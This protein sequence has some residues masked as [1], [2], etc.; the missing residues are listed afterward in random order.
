M[1]RHI[2]HVFRAMAHPL[3]R[4]VLCLL[5]RRDDGVAELTDLSE[6]LADRAPD[7]T[8]E[9]LQTVLYHDHL[10]RLREA[11]LVEFDDRTGTARYR[12]GPPSGLV[13]TALADHRAL[14]ESQQSHTSRSRI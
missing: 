14:R 12:D 9:E 1:K 8:D 4:E 13:G 3:R 10:P 7:R 11:G 5:A 2:D 6:R